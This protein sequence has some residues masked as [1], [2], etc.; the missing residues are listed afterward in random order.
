VNSSVSDSASLE[1]GLLAA[2]CQSDV[3]RIWDIAILLWSP[4]QWKQGLPFL[5][6]ADCSIAKIRSALV[7]SRTLYLVWSKG[8]NERV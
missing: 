4:I 5:I 7:S 2:F 8:I 3:A 6:D 1:N